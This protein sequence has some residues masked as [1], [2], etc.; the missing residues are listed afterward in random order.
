MTMI[1][2][3]VVRSYFERMG[4][5]DARGAFGLFASPFSYRVMGTTPISHV[6]HTMAEL[7]ENT[8]RP[9]TSR[10]V[11]SRIEIIP[12]EYIVDGNAVV[13]LAHSKSVAVTG[14]PYENEYAMVF[15]VEDGKITAICEYLDTA[16][17]ETAVFGKKL[18]D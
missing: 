13:V 18:V 7:V 10:L 9:F 8:L 3:E 14:M 12:D 17:V 1:A 6:S 16:L 5:G 11:D 4:A 15:R 2:E